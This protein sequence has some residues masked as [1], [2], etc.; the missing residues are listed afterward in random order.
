M[1]AW[2]FHEPGKIGNLRLEEVAVP[3]PKTG[4]VLV[5][6]AA[7]ALNPADHYLVLGQYPRAGA[8]PFTPGR[9]GAGVV[10]QA[11]PGGRFRAGDQVVLLGGLTG[12]SEQGTLAE[13]AA[14]PEDWLAPLPAGWTVREGAAAPLVYLTAWR[15]LVICGG[16]QAG[17]TVL[18]TGASGGVGTAAVMLANSLGARV[19]ALSRSPEKR[20]R[21][22]SLG[23]M[24]LDAAAPD[25]EKQVKNAAGNGPIGLIV[26]NLGGPHLNRCARMAGF[27]G[28]I[29][30][31]GLL[32]GLNAEVTVGLLIH[33]C[34][35]IEGISVS[36]YKADEARRAWEEIVGRLGTAGLRPIIDR[37]FPMTGVQEAFAHLQR[38]P[39][40]KVIIDTGAA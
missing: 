21:L 18:V 10:E 35:R 9:D 24:A 28:R 19:L 31:V 39:F 34:I 2:R 16:L 29:I 7:A 37:V 36:A 25:I 26:E 15:A 40:G 38:G 1:R 17:Q 11:C 33:K 22:E 14:V 30:V 3:V 6:M 12:I 23:A 27:G 20:A 4:E 5:R 13:C 32:A 8:P